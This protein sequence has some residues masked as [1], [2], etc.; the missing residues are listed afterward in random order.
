MAEVPKGIRPE[1]LELL[2]R[3]WQEAS[4][5]EWKARMAVGDAGQDEAARRAAEL[6]LRRAEIQLD[7]LRAALLLLGLES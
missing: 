5:Q 3:R 2:E 4:D 7:N 1:H 6:D